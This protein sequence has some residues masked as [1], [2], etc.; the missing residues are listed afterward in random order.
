VTDTILSETEP[1]AVFVGVK[2]IEGNNAGLEVEPGGKS[3]S[4][5]RKITEDDP[6]T[7]EG[8]K[9]C[10][11]RKRRPS[12][13]GTHA[14]SSN[15]PRPSPPLAPRR[16]YLHFIRTEVVSDGKVADSL[17]ALR[18]QAFEMRGR[19]LFRQRNRLAWLS[20]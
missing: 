15:S 19:R 9:S 8:K 4:G 7:A 17:D 20:Q 13:R 11:R 5:T 12:A 18:D 16:P 3:G 6:E 2:D 14:L 1:A 10:A